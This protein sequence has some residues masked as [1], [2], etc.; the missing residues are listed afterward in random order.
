MEIR[1]MTSSDVEFAYACTTAEGW[2]GETAEVFE[3]F[4]ANDPQGC[5]VAE[6]EGM[7]AGVSVATRYGSSGFVGELVVA[8]EM[9][10]RGI[11]A[12]LFR[13]AVE[14]LGSSGVESIYLD[15]DLDVVPFYERMGFRKVCRSL[16][17]VGTV[18]GGPRRGIRPLR[19]GDLPEV[20][21]LDRHLLGDDRSRY[22]ERRLFLFPELCYVARSEGRINGYVMGRPGV[23]V[24]SVGPWVSRG[25]E[26]DAISLLGMVALQAG[27]APLRLGV[28]EANSRAVRAVRSSVG[29]EEKPPCW[30]MVMG[31]DVG[32]GV[33]DDIFAIGSAA[34]G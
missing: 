28:L 32:L 20:C 29:F 23:G 13:A 27:D 24:V 3:T 19:P 25:S 10:G 26:R 22:I 15:G 30:R 6:H 33:H 7:P 17:F 4:L 18:A 2:S 8:K 21:A 9:R 34:K 14:Y 31:R 11:G 12:A 5:F 16:R 1:L